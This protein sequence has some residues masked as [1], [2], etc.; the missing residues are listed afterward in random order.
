M[1]RLA[2]RRAAGGDLEGGSARAVA[3]G[4]EELCEAPSAED[5]RSARSLPMTAGAMATDMRQRAETAGR[6][7]F[8]GTYRLGIAVDHV[9]G[10]QSAG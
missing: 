2:G 1:T 6:A 10:L 3:D 9:K 8:R 4:P 7:S 5:G